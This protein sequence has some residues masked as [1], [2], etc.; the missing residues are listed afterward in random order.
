MRQ[1]GLKSATQR[2]IVTLAAISIPPLFA[3]CTRAANPEPVPPAPSGAGATSVNAPPLAAPAPS[4]AAAAPSVAS[5]TAPSARIYDDSTRSIKATVGER[6]TINLPA[7]I[8][9]PYKWIVASPEGIVALA[10]RHYQEKPPEGCAGCVGYPGTD[11]L[12]FEAKE[13]GSASL[14]LRYAPLRSK[15][16][17]PE[18]ELTIQVT[19]AKP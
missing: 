11:R 6:F 2:L 7:N 14:L 10:E 5:A 8:A 9:T 13:A 12:T 16:D 17:P 15:S 4:E 19:V 3:A 1:L 18:R